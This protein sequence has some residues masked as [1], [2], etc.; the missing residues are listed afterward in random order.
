[1]V[2]C[3]LLGNGAE[4]VK[5]MTYTPNDTETC[6]RCGQDLNPKQIEWMELDSH[7]GLYHIDGFN[8]EGDPDRSQGWFPFG[9]ACAKT[10]TK[11]QRRSH[12]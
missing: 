3:G 6:Q 10:Q 5:D 1:M 11:E 8:S 4:A 2:G 9:T 7:T 12:D